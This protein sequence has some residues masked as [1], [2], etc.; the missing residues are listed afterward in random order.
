MT[1][2]S[3]SASAHEFIV[4]GKGITE[5]LRG[6]FT[7]G[8]TILRAEVLGKKLESVRT[9]ATGTFSVGPAGTSTY[10]LSVAGGQIYEVAS[11]GELV[12]LAGCTGAGITF[13][14]TDQLI[15]GPGSEIWDE[16]KGASPPVFFDLRVQGPSCS[17]KGTYAVEGTLDGILENPTEAKKAHSGFFKPSVTG[18]QSL[19][20]DGNPSSIESSGSM[21]LNDG[22][23]WSVN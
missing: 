7:S 9:D 18:S 15:S 10:E 19:T 20:L 8:T 11:N 3:A 13:H 14:G 21:T 12:A 6:T 22:A 17:L 2:T 1:A 23:E 4:G 16:F 5:V